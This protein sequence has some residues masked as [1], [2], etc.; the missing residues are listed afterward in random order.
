VIFV[1]FVS[2]TAGL[3]ARMLASFLSEWV[4]GPLSPPFVCP[5]MFDIASSW[6]GAPLR[7]QR[8]LHTCITSLLLL[9]RRCGSTRPS[10]TAR[11]SAW[12][13]EWKLRGMSFTFFVC[14]AHGSI[15]Q[16]P[17]RLKRIS[18]AEKPIKT[19]SCHVIAPFSLSGMLV[20]EV[21]TVS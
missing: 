13:D 21:S 4:D 11:A 10:S 7:D 20:G 17:I 14:G 1:L 15:S 12:S 9:C 8:C 19:S 16:P 18:S 6:P 5:A 3:V 2:L